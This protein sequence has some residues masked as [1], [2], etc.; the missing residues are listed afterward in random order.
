MVLRR[1]S[2]LMASH[3]CAFGRITAEAMFNGC[4]VIGNNTV[5]T[6][7]ENLGILYTGHDQLVLA[8]KNVVKNKIEFYFPLILKAQERAVALYSQE[9]NVDSVYKLYNEIISKQI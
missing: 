9:Q 8:L 4:L 3:N 6:K 5:G 2:C 1:F 7:P